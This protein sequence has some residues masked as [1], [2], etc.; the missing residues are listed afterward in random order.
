MLTDLIPAGKPR[1][2]I[3]DKQRPDT[4]EKHVRQRIARSLVEDYRY[5]KTDIEV[6]YIVQQGA[7]KKRV[8][9]AIFPPTDDNKQ[10]NVKIIVDCKHEAVRPTDRDNGIEQLKSYLS[11]CTNAKFGQP[12]NENL[13]ACFN[14]GISKE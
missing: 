14:N 12:C 13:I 4:P 7:S 8:D 6:E 1:C 9:M 5:N 2:V 10:E 11:V 3:T